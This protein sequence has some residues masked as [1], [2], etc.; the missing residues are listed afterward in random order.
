MGNNFKKYYIYI[1]VFITGAVILVLEILGTRI[2]APYYGTTV[3]VWSALIAV[4]LLA[5]TA[6]Y[7]LGGWISDKRPNFDLLYFIILAAAAAVFT[8]PF[9]APGILKATNGLGARA[10]SFTSAAVLFTVPLLLLGMASPFA[11]KLSISELKDAG[12]TTG[13]LY[14]VSTIG[15]FIGAI[16][17]GFFLIPAIGIKAIIDIMT[18]LLVLVS[19]SWFI[20]VK[21][22]KV[23]VTLLLVILSII[24]VKPHSEDLAYRRNSK[25][26]LDRQ[27]LYSKLKVVDYIDRYRGLVIDNALQTIYDKE[28]KDTAIGYIKMFAAASTQRKGIKTALSIGLGGGAIDRIFR[29][30]GISVDN[31]EIDPAVVEIAKEYFN[32]D[33]KVIIDDGR[34]YIRNTKKTYDL[35]VLDAYNG[36]SVAQFL[37]S[38]EAFEEMKKILNPGGLLLIN[39]V[40]KLKNDGKG[41]TPADRLVLAVNSTLKGVFTDVNVISDSFGISNYIY[42]ASD[43]P[44]DAAAGLNSVKNTGETVKDYIAVNIRKNGI[45]VT[46]NYNPVESLTYDIIED[47][48]EEEIRRLGSVF[49]L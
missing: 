20:A 42:S 13:S 29:D 47:W 36:F 5:L 8:I 44:L 2:I 37:L 43:G 17:T 3:Y 16:V 31:V 11:V 38:K 39:T 33:G 4:T 26:L 25:V 9:M 1:T 49:V 19:L 22:K 48:R 45:M 23:P 35:I 34:H 27:T 14:G 10:G 28:T 18:A 6:G 30:K 21:R 41:G 12:L 7:F 40:G 32:F 46:D 15:S 24:A